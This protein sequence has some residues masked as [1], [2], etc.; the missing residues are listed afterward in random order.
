MCEVGYKMRDLK[1]HGSLLVPGFMR[2]EG[3]V[4]MLDGK[5]YKKVFDKEETAWDKSDKVKK[6][7]VDY[8]YL[9]Q[10]VRLEK[11]LSRDSR[12]LDNYPETLSTI[13]NE[14]LN[15]LVDEGEIYGDEDVVN[16]VRERS[17]KFIFNFVERS[18]AGM[19][20]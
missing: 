11:L 14:Y 12:Y 5:R 8:N 3:V 15:D 2:P 19:G 20:L 16:I 1:L 4:I 18:V 10:P 7:E 13:V 6:D 17:S 9:C